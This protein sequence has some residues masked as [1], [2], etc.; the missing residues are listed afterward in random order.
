M[1]KHKTFYIYQITLAFILISVIINLPN[2]QEFIMAF[3]SQEKKAEIAPVVKAICK[4]YGI[5]A[6]L[7]VRNHSTLCLNIK[8]GGIDFIGNSNRVIAARPGGFRTGYPADPIK[9]HLDV[10]PYWF[11]EH[12]DGKA[13]AFLTEVMAALKGAGWYDESDAMTDYFDTAYYIDINVGR[14]DKPYLLTV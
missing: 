13:L 10:N 8:A 12:Y 9:Q 2:K 1:R 6:S 5:T 7:A 11:D 14:W 3:M 4:K